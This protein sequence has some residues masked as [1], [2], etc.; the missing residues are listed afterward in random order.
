ME[1]NDPDVC[2]FLWN[3]NQFEKKKN[4]LEFEPEAYK[5]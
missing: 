4:L 3:Y 5:K 1:Q 2:W